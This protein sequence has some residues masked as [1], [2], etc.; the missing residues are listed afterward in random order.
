MRGKEE[1]EAYHSFQDESD[2]VLD[3][4][5]VKT[6]VEMGLSDDDAR[7]ALRATGN[8]GVAPALDWGMEQLPHL[9]KSGRKSRLPWR[10]RSSS[11]SS[12]EGGTTPERTSPGEGVSSR[13]RLQLG[14]APWLGT[15]LRPSIGGGKCSCRQVAAGATGSGTN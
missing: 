12:A 10:G 2:V 6:L 3:E 9:S 11:G 1:A 4:A 13:L 8:K 14:T 15:M 5:S 7:A